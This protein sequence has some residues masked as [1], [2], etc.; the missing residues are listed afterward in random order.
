VPEQP[1]PDHRRP[2]GADDATVAAV[3]KVGEAYEWLIRARGSLYGFHQQMGRADLLLGE[4]VE[5]L[6]EAGHDALADRVAT[7]WVGR[8]ALP[9][10]WTFEVVEG[11]D[12]TYWR[13][14]TDLEREVR[15]A[16]VG[17]RRHV[18]ESEMKAAR[19]DGSDAGSAPGPSDDVVDTPGR[20]GAGPASGSGRS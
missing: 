14:A 19:R 20:A 2:D 17:G 7:E 13:V 6:R 12:D 4:A 11:F 10:R 16:L 9:D 8:N 18:H 1:D 15:E 5:Q 3:G